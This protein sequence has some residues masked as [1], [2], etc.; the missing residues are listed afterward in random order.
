DGL[1]GEEGAMKE[2][3]NGRRWIIDPIDGTRDFIRGTGSWSVLLGLEE[4]GRVVAGHAYFPVSGEMYSAAKGEGAFHDGK[5]I[6][7]SSVQTKANALICCNG[8]GFM[9]KFGF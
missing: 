1:L 7:A 3:V 2:S 9:Q 8:I 4:N 6:S 5:R